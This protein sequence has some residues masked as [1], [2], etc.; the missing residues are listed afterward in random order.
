MSHI[1]LWDLITWLLLRKKLFLICSIVRKSLRYFRIPKGFVIDTETVEAE[2]DLAM[3]QGEPDI[4]V[5]LPQTSSNRDSIQEQRLAV[6]FKV[7]IVML[8]KR[9]LLSIE[10]VVRCWQQDKVIEEEA[11]EFLFWFCFLQNPAMEK[12]SGAHWVG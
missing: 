4:V 12:L 2:A 6:D 8:V 1:I 7:D 5:L 9:E 3:L 11:D 10:G